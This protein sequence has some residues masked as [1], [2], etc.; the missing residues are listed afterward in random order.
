MLVFSLYGRSREAMPSVENVADAATSEYT[1]PP[2]TR[3]C[4]L[5]SR[6]FVT[7]LSG[8]TG[9]GVEGYR[10]GELRNGDGAGRDGR[11]GLQYALRHEE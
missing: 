9:G 8:R 2:A 6:G 7:P 11:G 4:L 1:G 10:D 5:V 3:N